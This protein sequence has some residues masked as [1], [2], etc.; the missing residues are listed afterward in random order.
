MSQAWS[1]LSSRDMLHCWVTA[2]FSLLLR[3]GAQQASLALMLPP[4]LCSASTEQRWALQ[5]AR[6][7]GP[8][9]SDGTRQPSFS[10]SSQGKVKRQERFQRGENIVAVS[11]L[12]QDC[13]LVA[14]ILHIRIKA[15]ESSLA[16]AGRSA[17][18]WIREGIKVLGYRYCHQASSKG[19][20]R[21]LFQC[22]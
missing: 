2:L 20:S 11:L 17:H 19:H 14:E 1:L 10:A 5:A 3:D 8:F 18:G 16:A 4:P 6:S 7:R 15:S 22:G 13:R 9:P 12:K 21:S